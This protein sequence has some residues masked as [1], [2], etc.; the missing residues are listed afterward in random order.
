[1][2]R[3]PAE[4]EP[5]EDVGKYAIDYLGADNILFSTDYPHSDSLFPD[6]V[7]TFLAQEGISDDDKR[8]ILWDNG[9]RLFGLSG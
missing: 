1:M 2:Q 7:D 3:K 8:K 9:A 5:E 4:I 6:A